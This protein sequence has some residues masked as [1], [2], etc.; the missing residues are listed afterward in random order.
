MSSGGPDTMPFWVTG[1]PDRVRAVQEPPGEVTSVYDCGNVGRHVRRPMRRE[2]HLRR[3][4]RRAAQ[5]P[6]ERLRARVDEAPLVDEQ[7]EPAI[8]M[9]IEPAAGHTRHLYE[10][11]LHVGVGRDDGVGIRRRS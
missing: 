2:D 4:A 8:G 5:D 3:G 6:L 11:A 1:A 10:T 9:L 7:R